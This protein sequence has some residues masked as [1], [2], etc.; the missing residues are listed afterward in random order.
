MRM[1]AEAYEARRC[2]PAA[3]ASIRINLIALPVQK[4]KFFLT[5]K[6]L[7]Y[8]FY[9]RYLAPTS[10][11]AAPLLLRPTRIVA[12]LPATASRKRFRAQASCLS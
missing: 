6:A 3:S 1:H 8:L 7:F 12:A 10:G 4:Y 5:R 11:E 2:C 9:L